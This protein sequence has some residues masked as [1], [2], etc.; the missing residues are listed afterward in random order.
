MTVT[1]FRLY[2]VH[3]YDYPCSCHMLCG[4]LRNGLTGIS[5]KASAQVTFILRSSIDKQRQ[6]RL[7]VKPATCIA[8]LSTSEKLGVTGRILAVIKSLYGHDSAVVRSLPGIF[9]CNFRCPLGLKQGCPLNPTLFE[10]YLDGLDK[11]LLDNANT[12]ASTLSLIK[13][14]VQLLLYADDIILMSES[15][16]GPPKQLNA[17]ASF[18][19]N[20]NSQLT[21]AR[22]RW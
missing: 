7:K 14:L 9:R 6:A 11:H 2:A 22:Q 12:D 21:S 18:C 13:V 16:A 20:V 19:K 10:L 1:I 17:P 8:A 4:G 5:G 15:A 3:T